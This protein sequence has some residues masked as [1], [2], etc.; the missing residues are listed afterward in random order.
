MNINRSD[1][2]AL[3]TEYTKNDA[4]IK[5]ALGVEAAMRHYARKFGQDEELWGITGLVHDFDYEQS[6]DPKDHPSRGCA[7]LEQKGYPP[8][9]IHSIK[10]HATYLNVPRVSPMDKTLFAVDELVG[11]ITAVALVRPSKKIAE[12]E[13]N[14][15]KK[16]FKDK[17]FA[18]GCNREDILKGTEELG[19]PLEEHIGHVLE[20]MK[21]VAAE[22]GL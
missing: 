6:P 2:F 17:A 7:I 20:A 12:V 15:V 18:R 16:K 9:I 5:H 1:A 13:V 11:L 14:S 4:L 3:L 19:L 8:E 10:G 21:G 22:L